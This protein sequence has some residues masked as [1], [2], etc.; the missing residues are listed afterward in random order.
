[1]GWHKALDRAALPGPVRL[2]QLMREVVS[3]RRGPVKAHVNWADARL[4]K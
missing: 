1:V 2:Q 4:I 3:G